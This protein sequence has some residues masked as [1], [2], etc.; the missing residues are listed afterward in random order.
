M[1]NTLEMLNV[2]GRQIPGLPLG[3]RFGGTLGRPQ[4]DQHGNAI[5]YDAVRDPTNAVKSALVWAGSMG[6]SRSSCG[7]GYGGCERT[8]KQVSFVGHPLTSFGNYWLSPRV[9]TDDYRV[10]LSLNFTD[11]SSGVFI[12]RVPEPPVAGIVV[13]AAGAWLL[14]RR[15]VDSGR[16]STSLT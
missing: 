6:N 12:A 16:K 14:R 7:W 13:I 5:F 9:L 11:G 2:P 10:A 4:L 8:P 3:W 1:E 15:Q